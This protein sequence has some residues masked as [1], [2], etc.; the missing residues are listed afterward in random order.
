MDKKDWSDDYKAGYSQG[1]ADI[2]EL[3][4]VL[5]ETLQSYANTM[6]GEQAQSAIDAWELAL[7]QREIR[8]N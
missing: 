6:V 1:K 5:V 4:K 2:Q 8:K 3:A 7:E